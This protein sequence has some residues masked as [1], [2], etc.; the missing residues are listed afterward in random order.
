MVSSNDNCE[1]VPKLTYMNGELHSSNPAE[2]YNLHGVCPCVEVAHIQYKD[3]GEHA[4]CIHTM[5]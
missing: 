3:P 2:A 4:F 5:N 1:R